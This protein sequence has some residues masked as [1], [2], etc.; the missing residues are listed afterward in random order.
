MLR[1][2]GSLGF[3]FL[4]TI[5]LAQTTYYVSTADG[6]DGDDGLTELSAWK[7]IQKSFDSAGPGDTVLIKSG[8]Y[9]ENPV[10]HVSGL[11][12]QPI[13]FRNYPGANP[14]IDGQPGSPALTIE[15]QS[16]LVLRGIRIQ[17]I[18]ANNAQGLLIRAT[19][20]GGVQNVSIVRCPVRYFGWTFDPLE[21]PADT[22]I[23]RPVVVRGEGL[24][25]ANAITGLL[26]DSMNVFDNITGYGEA[27]RVEGNVDG[28]QI[29]A[30][31]AY[32]NPSTGILINGHQ[33]VSADPALDNARNGWIADCQIWNAFAEY[34]PSAG[35]KVD[36]ADNIVIERCKSF[37]NGYGIDLGCDGDGEAM[38]IIARDNVILQNHGAGLVIGGGDSLTTGQVIDAE[39]RNNTIFH[40]DL[41]GNGS[42]EV[43]ITKI[44]N[45]LFRNNIFSSTG[46]DLL[47][48]LEAISPQT[49]NLFDYN[50][51]QTPVN[52]ST[53]AIVDQWGSTVQLT[54]FLIAMAWDLN[55]HLGDPLFNDPYAL[56]PD[57]SLGASSPCID[58]GDP[59]TLIPLEETDFSGAPRITGDHIDIGAYEWYLTDAMEDHGGTSLL[60]VP[61]PAED[62]VNLKMA[63]SLEHLELRD[64]HGRLV[65]SWPGEK[66]SLDLRGIVSGAYVLVGTTSDGGHFAARLVKR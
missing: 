15:D 38:G 56:E 9:H 61:N 51:W 26:L 17:G 13:I 41:D 44:S 66:R 12:G 18:T 55:G 29:H 3:I 45:C 21:V 8:S 34:A 40:N 60:L 11:P 39:V 64:I 23:V 42:G 36:G 57:L 27:I 2:P 22:N 14:A 4:C 47:L 32:D 65:R 20:D 28:F 10:M 30:C 19:P 58:A 49:G 46:Q 5:A 43:N 50:W 48:T 33:G 37:N 16:H 63:G 1:L 53:D 31:M 52:T 25:Q 62:L 7:T 54:D 59:A 35:I 24:T 6:N